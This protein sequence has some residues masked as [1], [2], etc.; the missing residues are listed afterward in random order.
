MRPTETN[1]HY[2]EAMTDELE[3]YILG[4]ELFWPLSHKRR[5]D[6]PPLPRMTIGNLL[7]AIRQLEAV[8]EELSPARAAKLQSLTAAWERTHQKWPVG[9]ER[10]AL[11]EMRSRLN[12][13]RAYL[14]DFEQQGDRAGVYSHEV[15]NRVKFDLLADLIGEREETEPLVQ[16]MQ[17]SDGQL[18]GIFSPGEFQWNPTLKKPYPKQKYW[19]L[20]G[21]PQSD[22]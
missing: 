10:K 21:V 8:R 13:W 15:R 1:L 6:R 12:L 16:A 14:S 11:V 7:T 22:R 17:S 5:S 20:Y 3:P 2:L 19:Y 9:I 18:R 4:S